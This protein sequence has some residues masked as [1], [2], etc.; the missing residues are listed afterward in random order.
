MRVPFDVDSKGFCIR[1]I[2]HIPDITTFIKKVVVVC[3]GFNGNRVEEHRMMIKLGELLEKNGIIMVRLDYQGQGLSSGQMYDVSFDGRVESV[4]SVINYVKGCFNG[5]KT[6][7]YYIIGFSDGA[8]VATRVCHKEIIKAII[9]WNPIFSMKSSPYMASQKSKSDENGTMINMHTKKLNYQLYGIP[10]SPKYLSSITKSSDYESYLDIKPSCKKL[11]IWGS[12]DRYTKDIR[13]KLCKIKNVQSY[14][15]RGAQHLF[16]NK[17][18]EMKVLQ[19]TLKYLL[20]DK[21]DK[22]TNF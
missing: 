21:S 1:G 18:Y 4:L 16:N 8:R 17:E 7:D 14:V 19:I 10:I 22:S 20:G 12:D 6:I 11:C 9:L 15:I 5:N 13:E 2:L 3:Y